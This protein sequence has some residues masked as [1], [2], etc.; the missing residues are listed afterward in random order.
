MG[1]QQLDLFSDAGL[2]TE[3]TPPPGAGGPVVAADMDDA[4]LIA[5]ISGVSLANG[6]LLEIGSAS[7]RDRV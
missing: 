3:A 4:E 6:D 1:E 5:A 7:C 2:R